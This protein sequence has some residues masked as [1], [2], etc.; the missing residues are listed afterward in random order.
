MF[1]FSCFS[2]RNMGVQRYVMV[3]RNASGVE[4]VVLLGVVTGVLC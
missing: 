1:E 2:K 3:P 4:I